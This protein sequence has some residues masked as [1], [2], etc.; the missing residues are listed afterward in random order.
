ML[1]KLQIPEDW[2]FNTPQV[3]R[4]FDAHVRESLPWYDMATGTVVHIARHYVPR[5]GTVV[6]V[7][8]STGN[9]G[10]ALAPLLETREVR[11]L[12]VEPSSNMANA[13]DGPGRI[14]V[15]DAVA[16]DFN[17]EKPD[18]VVCFLSLMFVSVPARA[19]L[20]TRMKD[21]VRS[22]GA[23]VVFDKMLPRPGYLGTVNYR[24]TLKAKHE[25]G[26]SAEEV[27]AKELSI[28]GSQRPLREEELDGF[29]EVFRFGDFA[30]F[31][32][33]KF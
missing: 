5:G 9:I 10:R 3:A 21:A 2:T 26:A 25:A 14:I 16:F 24:L 17:A 8:A 28:A 4:Y 15:E 1:E 33:E 29:V 13:Y 27:I 19:G 31:V 22:G 18:L 20:I 7:G 11:L 30:G 23:I 32:H 6:D 12:A